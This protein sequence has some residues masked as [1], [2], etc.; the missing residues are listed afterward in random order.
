[1]DNGIL[2]ILLGPAGALV[3]AILVIYGGWRKWWVFGWQYR[4]KC[5]EA[6]E[7]KKAA[8]EGT[9]VAS[10]AVDLAHGAREGE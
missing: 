4:E 7:W 1:M 8:L 2:D 6:D 5:D 9:R 3:F 10:R